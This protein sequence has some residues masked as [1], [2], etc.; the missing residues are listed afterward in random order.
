MNLRK[1]GQVALVAVSAAAPMLSHAALD[2][3]VTTAITGAQTDG[4]TLIGALAAAGAAVFIIHKLLK[5][6][7]VSL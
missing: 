7:G 3:G 4:A 2:A 1:L 5:R 6:F